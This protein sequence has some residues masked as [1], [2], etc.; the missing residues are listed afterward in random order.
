MKKLLLFLLFAAMGLPVAYGAPVTV[1]FIGPGTSV[2]YHGVYAG[3]YD[4][5]MS[6]TNVTVM[7]D[8]FTTEI[9]NGESWSA[10]V[11]TY[12]D[13]TGGAS[14]KFSGITKYSEAGWLY[15]QTAAATLSDRAQ[16]QGAIWNIMTPGSVA[17]DS[18]A[19]WYYNQATNGTHNNFNW[20]NVMMVLTPSPFNAGQEFLTPTPVPL[21]KS[22]W[23]FGSGVVGFMGFA[24]RKCR[25]A[26]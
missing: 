1:Q 10:N 13:V 16:I 11:F 23:L 21:P 3:Y 14:A 25:K 20:S 18:L 24:R 5:T 9:H 4:A 7:C 2:P 12:A 22:A 8:D 6:G 15:G 19:Q 17:M 26:I